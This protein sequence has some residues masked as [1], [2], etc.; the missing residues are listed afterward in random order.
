MAA[1]NLANITIALEAQSGLGVAAS[2]AGATGIEVVPSSGMSTAVAE[3]TSQIIQRSR[4]RKRP[5][6]GSRFTT[7]AY[8]SELMVQA[9]DPLLEG[10]L[11]GTWQA[12]IA[13]DETDLTSCTISGTGVTVTFAGGNLIT[14]GARAGMMARLTNMTTA[15]NNSKW[16]PILALSANGRVITTASGILADETADSAFDIEIARSLFTAT[17]YTDRYF[18]V[19][20]YLTDIDRSKLGTDMRFNE[21]NFQLVPDQPVGIGFGL[22][23]RKMEL[24]A[25]G[26]SPNFTSPAFVDAH[27]LSMLDG[28]IYV[29]GVLR[30][31]ISGFTFGLQAPVSGLP[32]LGTNLSPDTFLGQFS[33]AG[34]FTGAVEDGTDFDAFDAEDQISVF[35]RFAKQGTAHEAEFISV[36]MGNLVYGGWSTPAGGEGAMIQTIPLW[37]GEDER[38]DAAGY[39]PSSMVISTSAS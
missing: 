24:L 22:G 7:A 10:A 23:G 16:F 30:S 1:Q 37:G 36:Y 34:Q 39:A 25:S 13:L 5:R 11:G 12:A 31:N 15:G 17:P 8:Q 35:L 29:N 2:G 21:L 32:V 33:L 28:G 9:F 20:E 4:M 14:E 3:I 27:T 26:D 38:G 18:S 6:Q 19:E